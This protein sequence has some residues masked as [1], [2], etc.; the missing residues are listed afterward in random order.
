MLHAVSYAQN[1]R[2]RLG[3]LDVE[4]AMPIQRLRVFARGAGLWEGIDAATRRAQLEAIAERSER[5]Y[6]RLRLHLY[7]ARRLYAPPFTV[8]GMT[9]AALYLGRAYLVLTA[10]EQ[11]RALANHFDDLVRESAVAPPE[12]GAAVREIATLATG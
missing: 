10:T 11:V 5:D 7:D 9:R 6:P 8:F 2:A 12:T 4:I 1:L 3:D